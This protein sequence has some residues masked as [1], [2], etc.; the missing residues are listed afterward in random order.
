MST[1]ALP[2]SRNGKFAFGT[3]SSD[4]FSGPRI[5]SLVMKPRTPVLDRRFEP[6]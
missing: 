6:A 5:F 1:L 4:A 2:F 3:P